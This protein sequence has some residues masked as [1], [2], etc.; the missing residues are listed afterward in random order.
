MEAA[1]DE[2][3]GFNR[4]QF[5]TMFWIGTPALSLGSMWTMQIFWGQIPGHMS[6][7][8]SYNTIHT[9]ILNS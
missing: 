5:F 7:M 8:Y 4:F 9:N 2:V 1:I 3:G 6:Y